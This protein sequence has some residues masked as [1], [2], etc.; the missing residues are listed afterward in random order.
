MGYTTEFE[1]RIELDR[2]LDE[3]LYNL[4]IKLNH[5]RRMKRDPE[6]LKEMGFTGDYGVEGEFFVEG[7]GSYGQGE[8]DSILDY[9]RP[10]G[11]QPGLWCQWTPTDD[12]KGLEWDEGEKFYHAGEWMM[13]LVDRI[14]KPAGYVANGVIHAQGEDRDD[15]WDLCVV[16]N[17]V[18]VNY[19]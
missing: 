19:L 9:N 4:L 3:E 11:T 15:T 8:D 14:L 13:Y 18:F 12:R 16:N 2:A 1:G 5:T 17:K 7:T 6:K 10:P